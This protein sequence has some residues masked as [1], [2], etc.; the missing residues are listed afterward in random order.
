M[1]DFE[2]IAAREYLM[3]EDNAEMDSPESTTPDQYEKVF[4]DWDRWGDE[5]DLMAEYE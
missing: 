2:N 1:E 4:A 3:W 5:M